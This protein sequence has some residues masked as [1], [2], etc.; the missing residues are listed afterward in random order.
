M[1][2]G[3][4]TARA[5]R[6][7]TADVLTWSFHP[8]CHQTPLAMRGSTLLLGGRAPPTTAGARRA[9]AVGQRGLALLALPRLGGG[10]AS[11]APRPVAGRQ[12]LHSSATSSG[13]SA[14]TD[15]AA[16]PLA[17]TVRLR[18]AHWTA[19]RSPA[20]PGLL[21]LLLAVLH[22]SGVIMSGAWLTG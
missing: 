10:V 19:I 1:P 12:R 17:A 4:R 15:L 13:S 7:Q 11:T 5:N 8:P 6:T 20:S 21:S 16:Q 18:H 2:C 3:C 22:G 14:A 9:V